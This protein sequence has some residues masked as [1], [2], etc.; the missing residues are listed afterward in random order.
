[1]PKPDLFAK[2]RASYAAATLAS[3]EARIAVAVTLAVSLCVLTLARVPLRGAL[4]VD[5]R[6]GDRIGGAVQ[7][8]LIGFSVPDATGRAAAEPLARVVFN[9]PLPPDFTLRIDAQLEPAG[10][11]PTLEI[12]VGGE[13]HA[14]RV[15]R[16]LARGEIRVR[17]PAG[18]RE[19]GFRIPPGATLRV[20]R[21]GVV[22][23]GLG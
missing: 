3:T 13:R 10:A 21:I 15:E 7:A 16:S 2:L 22:E 23:D 6:D 9:R 19:I 17:N 12:V 5:F 18:A 20:Q 1:M 8:T 14:L 4:D 11:D